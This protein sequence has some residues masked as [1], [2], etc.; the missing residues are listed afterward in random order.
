MTSNFNP[1][2]CRDGRDLAR[3]LIFIIETKRV[4]DPHMNIVDIYEMM[5]CSMRYGN[6]ILFD[7]EHGVVVGMVCY[8]V[9]TTEA[10]FE[11][12]HIAHVDYCLMEPN[13]QGTFYFLKCLQF[14]VQTIVNEH[15]GVE[16]FA[17]RAYEEV[18]R[19][20]RLYSKFAQKTGQIRGKKGLMNVYTTQVEQLQSYLHRL[21]VSSSVGRR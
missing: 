5:L 11:D 6:V 1:M 8:T 21:R 14:L 2:V 7:N 16:W 17:M 15:N 9:G 10:D 4:A 19:N 18:K 20:N 13:L 3:C 12:T